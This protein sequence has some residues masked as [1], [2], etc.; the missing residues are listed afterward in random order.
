MTS[1]KNKKREP[2][3]QV[4]HGRINIYYTDGCWVHTYNVNKLTRA[5]RSNF[6]DRVAVSY[7]PVQNENVFCVHWDG[8]RDQ[9]IPTAQHGDVLLSEHPNTTHKLQTFL[10]QIAKHLQ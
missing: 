4:T 8:L 1:K 9:T 5:L 7:I 10:Q 3:D 2:C 6:G